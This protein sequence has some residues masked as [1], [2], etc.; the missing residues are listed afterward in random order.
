MK[1][2][3]DCYDLHLPEDLTVIPLTQL[4]P[5]VLLAEGHL[6]AD[7]QALTPAELGAYLMVLLDAPPSRRYFTGILEN[8]SVTPRIAHRSANFEMVR[9]MVGHGLGYTLL[10]TKPASPMTY[11]GHALVSRRLIAQAEPS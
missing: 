5:Y 11:G 1:L 2:N 8:A 7:K 6:I 4:S 9:C 10:A 3:W